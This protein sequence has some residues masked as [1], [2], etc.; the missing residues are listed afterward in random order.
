MTTG[1]INQVTVVPIFHPGGQSLEGKG[2]FSKRSSERSEL[3]QV[4]LP[5][6]GHKALCL[7]SITT[8]YQ[9]QTIFERRRW[10]LL[11]SVLNWSRDQNNSLWDEWSSES[12]ST[13][14]VHLEVQQKVALSS[15]RADGA[16]P[17]PTTG[18][19]TGWSNELH[20]QLCK[21][22]PNLGLSYAFATFL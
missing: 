9:K 14:S 2:R 19:G 17:L 5:F 11:A 22:D 20:C 3:S 10:P 4:N 7:D 8:R 13:I 1:R 21:S 6:G 12:T 18:E 15:N 16:N